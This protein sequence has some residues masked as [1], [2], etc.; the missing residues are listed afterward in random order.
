MAIIR[1][2]A[3]TVKRGRA[4]EYTF[5]TSIGRQIVRQRLNNSNYG[6][7]ARRT[8]T[9]QSRRVRWSNLVNFYKASKTWMAKAFE[10]RKVGQTDYNRFMQ[11]NI[12]Y[13]TVS[14]TKQMAASG[15]CV[16]EAYLISQG[17]LPSISVTKKTSS[18]QTDIA[19][20]GLAIDDSTSV[21]DFSQAVVNA[22]RSFSMGMQLSFVSYMQYLD[23]V[24]IPRIICTLYEVTLS[25]EDMTPLRKYLPDFCSQA[26]ED[27]LSTS[28]EIA[29]GAFAYILSDLS[30]GRVMV[31]TQRLITNNAA[32]IQQYSS[33]KNAQDAI[34]S[35]GVDKE[36]VLNPRTTNEQDATM[37]P[38]YI[39]Y[40]E[41][42]GKRYAAGSAP[43]SIAQ[44]LTDGAFLI[45]SQQISDGDITSITTY[46]YAN[47]D[48]SCTFTADGTN[49][50]QFR[51]SGSPGGEDIK[52]VNVV[53]ATGTVLTIEFE[54]VNGD[55]GQ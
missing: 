17:S 42:K 13:T 31:S 52:S 26:S 18:W 20:G 44:L 45:F 1:N 8:E 7:D 32:L 12:P 33:S 51:P 25:E 53:M 47:T 11:L 37:K 2:S 6:K 10:T 9:Q 48:T 14:F 39:Q 46:D 19:L 40:L 15:A 41:S 5:Y 50:V 35:Y 49:R 28:D 29:E 24:E 16:A 30:S 36:V 54:E 3:N 43:G 21:R 55:F 22:N 38:V 4:G 27:F 23:S 34:D